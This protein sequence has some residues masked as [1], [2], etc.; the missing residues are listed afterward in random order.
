MNLR[1]VGSET[2]VH[3]SV[4]ASKMITTYL[5]KAERQLSDC[6]FYEQLDSDSTLDFTQK[7]TRA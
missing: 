3:D 1:D 4:Q 5:Q 7:I 2:S 6:Q